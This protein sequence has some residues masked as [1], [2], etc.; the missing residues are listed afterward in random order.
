MSAAQ[1]DQYLH[2]KKDV[3]PAD[4]DAASSYLSIRFGE[5]RAAR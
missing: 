2:W 1:N 5:I 4:Y 3:D